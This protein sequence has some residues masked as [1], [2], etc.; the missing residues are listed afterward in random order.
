LHNI[1]AETETR[2]N[3]YLGANKNANEKK[4]N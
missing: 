4:N 3:F 2:A 1:K